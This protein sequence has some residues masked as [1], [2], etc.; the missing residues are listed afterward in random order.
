MI[1]II[2]YEMGN[3]GSIQNMLKKVGYD[4]II[5]SNKQKICDAHKIIL[6]GIGAFDTGM[7]QLGSKGL[8]ETLNRRVLEAGVPVLGVCLGMQ[9]ITK[10]SEEGT[11][12]GLGWVES[13]TRKFFFPNH[14]Q[15]KIPHMGWNTIQYS[16][17]NPCT[18]F[19][20]MPAEARFYFVHSY[21]VRC[22]NQADIV[23]ETQYG[24]SFVSS[25]ERENIFGVQ[26]H[27][28][29]SH[30]YGMIIYKNFAESKS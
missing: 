1:V 27:P 25:F 8:H 28:E 26:F 2:D 16:E 20:G 12:P 22:D 29:K 3:V 18:L 6:P 17:E 9:L 15:L 30:R 11:L 23:A 19:R 4:S 21:Y 10:N 13:Q 5:T 7:E 24:H 14:P